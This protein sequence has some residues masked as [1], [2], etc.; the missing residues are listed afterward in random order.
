MES[1]WKR[2][3]EKKEELAGE[4]DKRQQ[5]KVGESDVNQAFTFTTFRAISTPPPPPSRTCLH[6]P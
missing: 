2:E 1:K 4:I 5:Q 3:K 6:A